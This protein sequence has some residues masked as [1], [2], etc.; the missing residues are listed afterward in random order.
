MNFKAVLAAIALALFVSSSPAQE[1]AAATK[2]LIVVVEQIQ[3][4]LSAGKQ[5]AAELAPELKA[6]DALI[7][8]YRGQKTNEVAE[9]SYMLAALHAQVFGDTET[10]RELL[11]RLAADF[12]G[13]PIAVSAMNAA[14]T[15]ERQAAAEKAKAA[16]AGK[17]APEMTFT[18]ATRDGLRKLS[19]LKG[20]VV[21]I[22]F[23]ATWCGPCVDS[24]PDMRTLA[25]HYKETDV[26]ILGV[27]SLQGRVHGLSAAPIDVANDPKK[28]MALMHDYI[29]AKEITWTVAF[30]EQDV[31]NPEYGVMG[32]P[33][34]VVL[35]PDGTVRHP[36][37]DPRDPHDEKVAKIDAL[38]KEFG[39]RLPA[40]AAA[41]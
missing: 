6:F 34:M 20:K 30:S 29:K 28:E 37:M 2:D 38:L 33:H 7:A 14:T 10:A 23:W 15:L 41:K 26:V 4:K 1:P 40:P 11:V 19:D 17:P 16:L 3:A 24:F 39:K 32:I 36:D 22:D 27:T 9:I 35:A 31:F 12:A 25:A 8:K 21:I 13:T 18:W 5:T